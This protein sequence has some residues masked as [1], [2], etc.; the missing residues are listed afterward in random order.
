[1]WMV[2]RTIQ[3]AFPTLSGRHLPRDVITDSKGP[4]EVQLRYSSCPGRPNQWGIPE[5]DDLGVPLF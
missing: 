4:A 2:S 1:M 3:H 5:M